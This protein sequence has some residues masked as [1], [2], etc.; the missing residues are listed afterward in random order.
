MSPAEIGVLVLIITMFG[1]FMASL[2]WA[3]RPGKTEPQP[4]GEHRE[5]VSLPISGRAALR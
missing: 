5:Q 1:V 2:A 3:S 4:G